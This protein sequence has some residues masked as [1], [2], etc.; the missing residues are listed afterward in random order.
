MT[1]SCIIGIDIGGSSVKAGLVTSAGELLSVKK[2]PTGKTAQEIQDT[3][4]KLVT[5][6]LTEASQKQMEVCGIGIGSPGP[7]DKEKGMILNT[8]NLPHNT[9]L[10][11]PLQEITRLPVYLEND[12]N[13]FGLAEACFGSGKDKRTIFGITLGTGFGSCLII[14]G[15]LFTGRGNATEF[16]HT[17]IN[18]DEKKKKDENTYQ[19]SVEY[20]ISKA[21]QVRYAEEQGLG[22]ISPR[23]THTLAEQG[24]AKALK[25]F[26]QYGFYLG[27]AL[28]NAINTFDPDIVVI[29]G[30]CSRSFPFFKDAL[31]EQLQQRCIV[32]IPEI[33]VS[34][35]S[36]PGI[37]GAASLFIV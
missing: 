6:L 20:Y 1:S 9:L 4:K 10:R 21:A 13:C 8:P 16:G 37:L 14:D 35:L 7:L 22:Q 24:N 18:F 26:E 33:T 29:G 12:A 34:A 25:V 11:V 5:L 23:E 30:A 31:F 17:T 15:K 36:E 32:K 28:A 19:G 27:I 3:L 2:E